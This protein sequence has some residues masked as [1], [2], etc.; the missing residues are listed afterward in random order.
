M[1]RAG[2]LAFVVVAP[3]MGMLTFSWSGVPVP[4]GAG[5]ILIV[6]LVV[7]AFSLGD[8]RYGLPAWLKLAVHLLGAIVVVAGGIVLTHIALP[9]GW[10]VST[11][12]A[13]IPATVLWIVG[14]TNAYNFMDG[15]DGLAGGQAVVTLVTIAWLS[16]LRGDQATVLAAVM[17]G[18]GVLG[19]LVHNWPPARIFMGDVG[20]AFLGFTFAA[21]ALLPARSASG[22]A[23]PFLPWVAVMAP[24]LLDTA[25]TLI[26]RIARG[27]PWHM[28]HRQ[29]LY[30]KLVD[31][32]WSHLVVTSLYLAVALGLGFVSVSAYGWSSR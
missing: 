4:P 9:G 10:F 22:L 5:R 23:L 29:H 3:V 17:L 11:G 32:G 27:E 28:A 19:F 20:S 7:A 2:G 16:D 14:L 6:G 8:D 26:W 30:Q 31:R 13:A 24:F 12:W 21:W 15:I 25:T 18:A 1:P